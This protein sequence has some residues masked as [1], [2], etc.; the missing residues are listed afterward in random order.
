VRHH[1]IFFATT[2]LQMKRLDRAR[3]YSSQI[4]P[5]GRTSERRELELDSGDGGDAIP[6]KTKDSRSHADAITT[7]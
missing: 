2:H 3:R 6:G 7:I 1:V 5:H 4:S